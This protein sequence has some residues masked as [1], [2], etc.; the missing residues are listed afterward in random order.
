MSKV[1]Q[2]SADKIT[3][4]VNVVDNDGKKIADI[5]IS[6]KYSTKELSS[7]FNPR[8]VH[9]ILLSY[10]DNSRQATAKCKDRSEVS[11]GGKKP[12]KQK[13]TGRARHGSNRSPLWRHG[14]VTFGPTGEQNFSKA[15]NKK[16]KKKAVRFA[17][18]ELIK[19][20]QIIVLEKFPEKADS[21]GKA[22]KF[23]SQFKL[24]SKTLIALDKE[25]LSYSVFL[26]NLDTVVVKSDYQINAL[27]IFKAGSMLCTK[28]AFQ[29]IIDRIGR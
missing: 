10:L 1:K 23:I 26:D 6:D 12:W 28:N 18:L 9:Q 25:S 20:S 15:I 14:G 17:L 4:M 22:N 8:F 29:N 11:G 24:R 2:K 27:D 13:G 7:G 16:A 21:T 3:A 5:D 19:N